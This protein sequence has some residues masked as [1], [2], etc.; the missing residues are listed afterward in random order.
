MLKRIWENFAEEEK[1]GDAL[2]P[3]IRRCVSCLSHLCI[4]CTHR[5][6]RWY[7][8][9]CSRFRILAAGGDG[10]VA[11]LLKTIKELRLDPPPLL[12]VMPLGTGNDLSLSF[13]WG[14]TFLPA[15]INVRPQFFV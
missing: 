9:C 4:L 1:Q 10:T 6:L 11:W 14:N 5:M 7:V 13:G 2:G 8:S 15:W 12:A 3:V